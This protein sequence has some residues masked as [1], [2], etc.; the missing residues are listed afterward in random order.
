MHACIHYANV[1]PN[2][3]LLFACMLPSET[4]LQ[5]HPKNHSFAVDERG[6]KG[7]IF[8]PIKRAKVGTEIA[9]AR[10]MQ[11]SSDMRRRIPGNQC[12]I[13]DYVQLQA[14]S[15]DRRNVNGGLEWQSAA[16]AASVVNLQHLGSWVQEPE[17]SKVSIPEP[18]DHLNHTARRISSTESYESWCLLFSGAT[19]GEDEPDDSAANKCSPR[20]SLAVEQKAEDVVSSWPSESSCVL[21]PSSR[22]FSDCSGPPGCGFAGQHVNLDLSLSICGS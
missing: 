8:P 12:C 14:M 21:S 4:Q 15:M 5:L 1:K 17:P 19:T 20:L 22:S 9:A 10:N 13:D 7:F 11:G 6:S 2:R 18:R 3:F 16:T